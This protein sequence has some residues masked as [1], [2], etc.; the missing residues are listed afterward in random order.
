M[1]RKD[2]ERNYI[3]DFAETRKKMVSDYFKNFS[4]YHREWM[5][6]LADKVKER[7]EY[8]IHRFMLADYYQNPKDKELALMASLV[9][10]ENDN[11]LMQVEHLKQLLTDDPT[12]WYN[13]RGFVS[14]GINK[15]RTKTINGSGQP[16]W[17]LANVFGRVWDIEH[18]TVAGHAPTIYMDQTD[19]ES[20]V[21]TTIR[22]NRTNAWGA[23][24]YYLTDVGIGHFYWSLNFLALRLF[25]RD[26]LG[27]GL[28]G[29]GDEELL[30]PWN[31]E[32]SLFLKTW[33]PDFRRVGTPE[34]CVKQFELRDDLDFFYAWLGYKELQKRNPK[35]CSEYSTKYLRWY[36]LGIKKRP[37]QMKE[38][39]PEII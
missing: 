9:I 2:S 34:F 31:S 14:L 19:F 11:I 27:M 1:K 35:A 26:G 13:D 24:T 16:M 38:I 32:L 4:I 28:W 36:D 23:L 17:K 6:K 12:S 3:A 29:R 30:C 15:N 5:Q 39:M 37:S 20:E 18:P 33:F 21:L 22:N 25:R 8:G 7:G 10:S